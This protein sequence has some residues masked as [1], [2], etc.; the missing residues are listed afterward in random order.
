MHLDEQFLRFALA[1]GIG[2]LIGLERGW[3]TREDAA[4]TRTAGIR[5]FSLTGL[6]GGVF[7][8]LANA[9]GGAASAGGGLLLG[10]GFAAFAAVFAMFTRDENKAEGNFS[11]TTTVAG[12]VT[13]ALGAYALLGEQ[14]IAA[15]AA[16]AV[17]LLLAARERLHGWVEQLT[18]RELRSVLMLLAMTFVALPL[19]P[20]QAID[21]LGGLNLRQIWTV[22]ILL[23]AV[24]FVGYVAVKAF[25]ARQ[26]VLLAAAAGGLV[27]STA[28]MVTN[29]RR[30]AQGEQDARVLAGGAMLASAVSMLRTLAIVAVLNPA[31]LG[32]TAVP[33]LA[34]AAVSAI[35][36]FVLADLRAGEDGERKIELRNPF[37]LRAVLS[38]ALLLGVISV[39]ARLL[40]ERYGAAGALVTAI[41]TGLADVD[42]VTVSISGLAP[43]T[44]AVT[45]AGYAILAAVASNMLAKLVLGAVGGRGAFALHIAAMTLLAFLAAGV[46]LW[47]TAVLALGD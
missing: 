3:R 47:L 32:V 5:T 21:A 11:A 16:V 25:G 33:L 45:T 46:G 15:A 30:A 12:L 4:G 26:G 38:F 40:S 17:A 39:V 6:L 34:A 9:L 31:L 7:G 10:L 41:A 42:A 37:E 14:T 1:L 29:A 43:Q 13:F 2:L 27:S 20:D 22:A 8:A 28:V 19:V 44:L 23:A 35:A 18:W 24:S 36:A